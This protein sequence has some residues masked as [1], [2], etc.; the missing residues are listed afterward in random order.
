M[1]APNTNLQVAPSDTSAVQCR[2]C[3]NSFF[4]QP[5]MVRRVSRLLTGSS[6][7]Q[8]VF[9]PVLKCT[10][11]GELLKEF[12]PDLPEF[13]EKNESTGKLII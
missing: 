8:F 13:E 2:K 7:D 10:E 11:C 1:Q 4:D 5:V 9:L 3:N 12:L 6:Q